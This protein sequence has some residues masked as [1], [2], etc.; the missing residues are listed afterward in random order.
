[1]SKF[2]HL[3]GKPP[4]LEPI[5]NTPRPLFGMGVNVVEK[6][7][8]T[9]SD[10]FWGSSFSTYIRH[11]DLLGGRYLRHNL[12]DEFWTFPFDQ[13]YKPGIGDAVILTLI[14]QDH[15]EEQNYIISGTCWD[16]S[17]GGYRITLRDF[18][19]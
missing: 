3:I 13:D 1:M 9:F 10:G 17:A 8:P 2:D 18:E 11:R 4:E 12:S 19:S 15:R 7:Y 6:P 5:D 16:P 14:H